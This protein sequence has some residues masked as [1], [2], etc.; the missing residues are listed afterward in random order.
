MIGKNEERRKEM[1]EETGEWNQRE[2]TRIE[3]KRG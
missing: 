2:E 1:Q 3:K